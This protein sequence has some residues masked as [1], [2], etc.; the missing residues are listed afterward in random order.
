VAHILVKLNAHSRIEIAR[1][2]MRHR[3]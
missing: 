3:A 2:A 1:E